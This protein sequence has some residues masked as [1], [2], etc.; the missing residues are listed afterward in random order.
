LT[1]GAAAAV[2][3][4]HLNGSTDGVPQGPDI[5]SFP[6]AP[7]PM[8]IATGL[9]IA[10]F[11]KTHI[12]SFPADGAPFLEQE[13]F[14]ALAPQK[15]IILSTPVADTSLISPV[16]RMDDGGDSSAAKGAVSN[17]GG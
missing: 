9:P 4:G 10:E 15:P 13:S 2:A 1:F 7:S 6:A 16:M 12:E 14:P 3:A 11:G 8:P 17:K 5:E